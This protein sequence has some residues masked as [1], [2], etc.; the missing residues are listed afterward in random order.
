MISSTDED[1]M[2]RTLHHIIHEIS[3]VIIDLDV[4]GYL[5]I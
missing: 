2:S 4:G 3:L 5:V 1:G